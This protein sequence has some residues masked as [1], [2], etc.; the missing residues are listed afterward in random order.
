VYFYEFR[1]GWGDYPF[2]IIFPVSF[3]FR[4]LSGIVTELVEENILCSERSELHVLYE[5]P[6]E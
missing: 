6:V 4:Y 1:V 2:E 3:P 5:H